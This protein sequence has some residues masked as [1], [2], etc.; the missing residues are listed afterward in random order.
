MTLAQ[1]AD[2]ATPATANAAR[3]QAPVVIVGAGPVGVRAL[4]EVRRQRPEQPVILYG[5]ERHDPY[6]RVQLSGLLS[7]QHKVH[8]LALAADVLAQE[9]PLTEFRRCRVTAIER[10]AQQ[11]RD[12]RGDCQPYSRLI[13]A[14]G[15]RPFVPA[16]VG[17]TL[18]GV[19]TFRDMADAEK[20]AA[21]RVQ[22]KH[23]LVLGAGLLGVEAAH[24]MRRHNTRVTLID[25]N[26]H[27]MSR[28]LDATAGGILAERLRERGVELLL[29]TSVRQVLGTSRVEGVILRDGTEIPCDTLVVATGIRPNMDLAIDAGLAFGRGITVNPQMQTSDPAIYAVGECCELN[30]EVFGLVAPG[31]EQAAIA[32][33]NLA[34]TDTADAASY[35]STQLATSLKVVGLPV[36]ASGVAEPSPAMQTVSWRAGDDYRRLTLV[37]GRIVGVNAIGDWT[38]L[39]AL[40]E[41]LRQRKWISPWQLWRFRRSGDLLADTATDD[42]A[43][44]PAPTV[45]CSCNAVSVGELREAV[46]AGATTTAALTARTQA[47]SGCGSC[48]PLLQQLLGDSG[49]LAPGKGWRALATFTVPALVIAALALLLSAPYPQS[50]QLDWD[51]GELWRDGLLKQISGFT[52]V[53]L[54]ALSVLV[55]LRKRL[56]WLRKLGDFAWWRLAHVVLTVLAL[57]ALGAHTGFR[58]GSQLNFAL[59]LTFIAL[60]LAGGVL[61]VSI[62]FEHRLAPAQARRLRRAGLWS[63]VLLSWPLPALLAAHVLKTYYF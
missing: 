27:P 59:G 54:S 56:R 48:K 50:V 30:G 63:H 44:W 53:G 47:G 4:R 39:P 11:V 38:Q 18:A 23:T 9:D 22:S 42:V 51:W 20:L 57:A 2:S 19:Y 26:P 24:G 60:L 46:C 25:H 43:S 29:G 34:L 32:A 41:L 3:A 21:R 5:E 62:A 35:R 6:N 49:P 28:Q 17:D 36:F 12:A 31:Y 45:V 58:L 37:G 52:I 7:G 15:S 33:R 14:T 55:S 40:R 8:E 16:L 61:G 1:A 13:L 10:E